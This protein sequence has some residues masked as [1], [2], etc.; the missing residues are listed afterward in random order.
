[1]RLLIVEDAPRL[2]GTLGAS[3]TH[4]GHAVDLAAD[5]TEGELLLT[6]N[7]YDAVVLDIML[8]GV[9]GLTLLDR[10][11]RRGDSTRGPRA[12]TNTWCG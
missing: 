4:L 3:L 7:T 8:P 9:D 12:R 6:E 2:R 5:G 11:R 1:M 10:L